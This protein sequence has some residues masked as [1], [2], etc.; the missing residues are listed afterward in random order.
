[1]EKNQEM[2]WSCLTSQE[3]NSLLLTLSQGL[4]TWQASEAL[5]MTHYKYLEL[6]ARSETFFKMFSDYFEKHSSLI[7]P[8]APLSE[9]FSYYLEGAILKRLSKNDALVYSGDNHWY[10]SDLRTREIERN[11]NRLRL[12][13]D[14]WCQDL[15]SLVMEFD[16][17]N[18]FRILPASIQAP[19]AYKR[20]SIKKYKIYLRFLYSIPDFRINSIYRKYYSPGKG[21]WYIALI[22]TMF[23][24]SGYRL[25][26]LSRN[27]RNLKELTS[28]KIYVFENK[29]DA[30]SFALFASRFYDYTSDIKNGQNYWPNYQLA[31]ERALNYKEINHLDFTSYSL[32]N[33]FS[34]RRRTIMEMTKKKRE[35]EQENH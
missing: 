2:A 22:S 8:R 35:I 1:M 12:V 23:T 29:E 34:L 32:S 20:R 16:R 13:K 27:S 15:Y 17:W 19:S 28:N 9:H 33:A 5:S 10:L 26:P 21:R 18:N 31:I 30:E 25:V 3:Q 6:K 14:E 7:P 11:M 24:D 4:S